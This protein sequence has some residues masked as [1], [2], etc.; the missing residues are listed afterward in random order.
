MTT[1]V[2]SVISVTGNAHGT[3]LP[4]YSTIEAWEAAC[5]SDLVAADQVWKGLCYND[6]EFTPVGTLTIGGNTT[7][8]TR[9]MWLTAAAG[10][11]FG[12]HPTALTN[13]LRYDQTKGVGVK[14]NGEYNGNNVTV[15]SAY[16]LIEK[17]QFKFDYGSSQIGLEIAAANCTVRNSIAYRTFDYGGGAGTLVI[18]AEYSQAINCLFVCDS[19]TQAGPFGC[20]SNSSAAINC[21]MIS[22]VTRTNGGAIGNGYG[23][24]IIRNCLGLGF[25]NFARDASFYLGAGSGYNATDKAYVSGNNPDMGPVPSYSLTGLNLAATVVAQS[26]LDARIKSGALVIGAGIRDAVF[27]LDLDIIGQPRSLTAPTIGCWEYIPPSGLWLPILSLPGAI[28]L[29]TTTA[30]PQVTLTFS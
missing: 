13:A 17:M 12:E 14:A 20:T 7:D 4:V 25:A 1:I 6:G 28:N 23:S 22:T 19:P 10:Q 16:T 3:G 29:T 21:T 2:S 27:T 5:P 9:Y 26:V 30:Q 24:P 15:S 11:S 8:A 18:N